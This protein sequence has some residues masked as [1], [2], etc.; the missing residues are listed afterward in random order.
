MVGLA[1]RAGV[2]ALLVALATLGLGCA[3]EVGDIDRTQTGLLAKKIFEGEW[4]MKRTVVD[5]PYDVAYTFIGEADDVVRVR[6]DVQE[7]HLIAYRVTPHIEGTSDQA[8]VAAFPVED[9]VDVIREYNP[10]TGEQ[11]NVIVE[12]SDDRLWFERGFMRVD[13]A[14]DELTNFGFFA[15]ALDQQPVAHYVSDE[16]DPDRMVVGVLQENGSWRD[17]H[18]QADMIEL[19][20]AQ[21]ID[22]VTRQALTPEIVVF[23]DYDGSL[24]YEPACWYYGTS[25]CA[26]AVVSIRSSFARVD[27]V[28]SDYEPLEYPDNYIARGG[29]GEPLRVAWNAE[30]NLQR[31]AGAPDPSGE[32]PLPHAE[33][34]SSVSDPYAETDSSLVRVPAISAP[35]ATA[36]TPSTERWR[37]AGST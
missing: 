2:A 26:P 27:A 13:W 10:A 5:A 18:R 36:T 31:V 11:S 32:G 34:P 37:R 7:K 16:G 19:D 8:A 14:T 24:S 25:D 22:L 6:W 28:L 30:G 17:F 21:Y 1:S 20:E 4:F 3:Q 9:H 33:Q 29:A 23:E 12:D 35:S 15:S